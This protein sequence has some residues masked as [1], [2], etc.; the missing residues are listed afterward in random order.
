MNLSELQG[1][2]IWL[3][4]FITYLVYYVA[5]RIQKHKNF[6]GKSVK[7]PEKCGVVSLWQR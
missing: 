2:S 3:S 6:R 4:M 5:L 1:M 7:G